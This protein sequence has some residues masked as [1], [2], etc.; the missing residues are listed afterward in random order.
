MRFHFGFIASSDN[1]S[2]RPG[3]GYKEYDR[4]PNTEA[5]GARDETWYDRLNAGIPHEPTA[6]SVPFDA[7]QLD[8]PELPGARLRAPGLVLPDRRPRRRAR[9]RPQP[10]GDL[11]FAERREVY[12]TSGD[13]I[14]LWFDLLNAPTG[15]RGADGRQRRRSPRRRASACAPPAR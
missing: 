2:A 12:G 10:R 9:D 7:E 5:R 6:E 14:L 11:G 15:Q 8:A 1:H 3:T 4:I 13:R